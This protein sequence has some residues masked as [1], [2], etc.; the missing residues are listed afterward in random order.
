MTLNILK[1]F[2]FSSKDSTDTYHK[3]IEA[4]KLAYA[5]GKQ[6]ITD[7]KHMGVT[8]EELLST[9]YGQQRQALIGSEASTP[10]P[11]VPRAEEQFLQQQTEGQMVS[12][13]KVITWLQ[14]C[15]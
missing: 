4:M 7:P 15:E 11:G 2:E 3:Q 6:Y 14:F 9:S 13:S 8:A 1:G 5:C 12:L 10:A